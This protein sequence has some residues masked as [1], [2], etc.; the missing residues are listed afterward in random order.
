MANEK[1]LNILRKGVE[2]WNE[3]WKQYPH[4]GLDLGRLDVT[5]PEGFTRADLKEA[6]LQNANLCS[7]D[8]GGADL[9]LA[10]L[11]SSNLTHANLFEAKLILTNLSG[12]KLFEANLQ[13][14]D[15]RRADL[16]KTDLRGANL[17]GSDLRGAH[18]N[19]ADLREVDLNNAKVGQTTFGNVDFSETK[20]LDTV[21]HQ[22]P[23][24]IGIDVIYKSKGNI[25]AVFLQRAGVPESLV[26]H[27]R[28]L[29][30]LTDPQQTSPTGLT[31]MTA[32]L[33][34]ESSLTPTDSHSMIPIISLVAAV[35]HIVDCQVRSELALGH[36]VD[37]VD[38]VSNLTKGIRDYWR[39]HG[40]PS[41][42][43]SR[44]LAQA[45]EKRFG[46]DA[47]IVIRI[48][49]H[50]KICIF[51]AKWPRLSKGNYQ[52]DSIQPSSGISHFSDQ[53]RR[54]QRWAAQAAIWELIILEHKPGSIV[55]NYD[56]W[57]ST[58]VLHRDAYPFDCTYRDVSQ[59]WTVD[60]LDRLMAF[61]HTRERNIGSIL[62]QACEC[63]IG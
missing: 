8:L 3:W 54:Q 29:V 60:D 52:W 26:S 62:Q 58:C 12:A 47:I 61:A 16:F 27:L 45:K 11:I 41:Y 30:T 10:N 36:I 31:P 23:S 28:P 4:F 43:Y 37:E 50:A 2:V 17:S 46:C 19:G 22:G 56:Q 25:P 51:E 57:A 34:L 32:A 42:A 35:A 40:F 14:A 15:L 9:S 39:S 55:K 20:G 1:H 5:N 59:L 18:L 48:G 49:D 7:A 44:R 53:L 6:R 21:K 24:S 33:T 63:K 38:Y 13:Q